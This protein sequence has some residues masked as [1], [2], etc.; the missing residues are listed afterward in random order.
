VSSGT[1]RSRARPCRSAPY[2]DP[3]PCA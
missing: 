1:D 3:P 2:P